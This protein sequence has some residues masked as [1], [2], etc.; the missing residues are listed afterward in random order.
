MR[1]A[2][3]LAAS[4]LDALVPHVVPGVTTGELDEIVRRMTLEAGGVPATLGYRTALQ[5]LLHLDQSRRCRHSGRQGP[6][7]R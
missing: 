1:R 6:E 5:E 3:Q 4:I 7:G 2:G